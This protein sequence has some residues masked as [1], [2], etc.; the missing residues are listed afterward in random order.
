LAQSVLLWIAVVAVFF[1][2][3]FGIGVLLRLSRV[4]RALEEALV[5][6]TEEMRETLPEVREGLGNVN[7]IAA[8]VNVALRVTGSGAQQLGGNAQL[9]LRRLGWGVR[10]AVYG[11]RI[12]AGSLASSYAELEEHHEQE[13]AQGGQASGE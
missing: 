10:A 12:G 4:L 8:G 13:G 6:A 7:D 9:T 5:T 2:A 11:V 3:L 1:L